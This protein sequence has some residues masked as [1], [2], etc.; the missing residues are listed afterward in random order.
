MTLQPKLLIV[1]MDSSKDSTRLCGTGVEVLCAPE[2]SKVETVLAKRP[3]GM[4]LLDE[5]AVADESPGQVLRALRASTQGAPVTLLSSAQCAPEMIE[6]AWSEG[7]SDL[8]FKPLSADAI[9]RRARQCS[10]EGSPW[11]LPL[12]ARRQ[13]RRVILT[14]RSPRKAQLAEVLGLNG[15]LVLAR[16]ASELLPNES[17][18]AGALAPVLIHCQEEGGAS[19]AEQAKGL[20]ALVQAHGA[21]GQF[22]LLT[23]GPV[24]AELSS[25]KPAVL[26]VA[27]DLD[28]VV[29]RINQLCQ[30]AHHTMRA[31]QRVPFFC[32]IEFREAVGKPGP[33]ETG[34]SFSVSSSGLFVRTLAPIRPGAP[35][36]LKIHFS[37]LREVLTL[38]GVVAWA[39]PCTKKTAPD[40]PV[41][42][43]VQFLGALSKRLAQFIELCRSIGVGTEDGAA[44]PAR[45]DR[46]NA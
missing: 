30:R 41:G 11:D 18:T 15:F 31:S 34:Y 33:F 23:D 1:G 21:A 16:E 32:P 10:S 12:T 3:V 35:V 5:S 4:V 20:L 42:M 39:N 38:T 17:P 46:R 28:E 25:L 40:H 45:A 43:G 14:G 19:L 7:L 9:S 27:T 2:P 29:H 6:E 37:T 26:P 13:A 36:E 22:V 8:L 44:A 24:P